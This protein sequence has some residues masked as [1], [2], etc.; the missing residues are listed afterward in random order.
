MTRHGEVMRHRRQ[1]E[2]Q[3]ALLGS[4]S[5]VGKLK[6]EGRTSEGGQIFLIIGTWLKAETGNKSTN[7]NAIMKLQK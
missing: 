5:S 7:L 4:D 2:R 1:M 6:G 3:P